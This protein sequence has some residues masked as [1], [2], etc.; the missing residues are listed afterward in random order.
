MAASAM[1]ANPAGAGVA[2]PQ[3]LQSFIDKWL[4]RWPEWGVAQVF[5]PTSQRQAAVAWF[6]LRHELTAAAWAGTDRLPGEA[7]LA[8]WAEELQGWAQGRRRHPLGIA[9]Q[10]LPAPWMRLAVALPTLAASRDPATDSDQAATTL[11][12]FADAVAAISMAL[13]GATTGNVGNGLLAEQLLLR[14]DAAVPLRRRARADGALPEQAAARAWAGELLRDWPGTG[15]N[16]RPEQIH[17]ALV[18]ER[19]GRFASGSPAAEPASRWRSLWIA[20]RAARA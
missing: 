12:P 16:A 8:W 4:A 20:W 17:A 18:H 9:L 2:D 7:K 15:V 19:L 10:R 5:V 1:S 11:A 3:A 6:A 14:G 13:F